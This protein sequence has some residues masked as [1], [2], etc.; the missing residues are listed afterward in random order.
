MGVATARSILEEVERLAVEDLAPSLLD[1]DRNPPIYDP[2]TFSATLPESFKRSYKQY[3][4]AEWW[5][6]GL[7]TELGGTPTPRS[8]RWAVAELVLRANPAVWMYTSGADFATVVWRLGTEE[9]RKVSRQMVD[10]HWGS[11]MVVTE[12][13]AGP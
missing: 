3:M 7:P 6:L 11:P 8:L 4:D 10:H 2:N 5:R 9:Q 1:S 13:G 12:P